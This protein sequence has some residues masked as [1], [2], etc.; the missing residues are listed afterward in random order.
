MPRE[1]QFSESGSRGVPAF[2]ALS[3]KKNEIRRVQ[4]AIESELDQKK[5]HHFGRGCGGKLLKETKNRHGNPSLNERNRI[6]T[7]VL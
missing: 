2:T 5:H 1:S 6:M 3:R 4:V 7:A